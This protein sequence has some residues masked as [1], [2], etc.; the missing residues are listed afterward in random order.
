MIQRYYL[1]DKNTLQFLNGMKLWEKSKMTSETGKWRYFCEEYPPENVL[2]LI[3][4]G[5]RRRYCIARYVRRKEENEEHQ[6]YWITEHNF[7]YIIDPEQDAW[8]AFNHFT[9]YNVYK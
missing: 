9:S 3:F 6:N 8:L 5:Q 7:L 2:L 1:V 4:R